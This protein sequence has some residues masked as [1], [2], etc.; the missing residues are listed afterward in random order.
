MLRARWPLVPIL[1]LLAAGIMLGYCV[2][3]R[4]S[5]D[6]PVQPGPP[7][8]GRPQGHVYTIVTEEPEH[9][10]PF[11]VAGSVAR[12]KVLAFTHDTLLETD[13]V[14]GDLRGALAVSWEMDAD[15]LA[16]TCELRQGVQFSDGSPLDPEDILFTWQ[17]AR[18]EDGLLGS[19]GDGM[20][21]VRDAHL[22]PGT[23]PRLR[24]ELKERHFAAL[25]AVAESW[26]VVQRSF[27]VARVA[28]LA[29]QQGLELPRPG[30]PA[31]SRLLAQVRDSGPGSGPYALGKDADGR[32]DWRRGR[33]LLLRRN[34]HC[35]RRQ[36]VPGTWNL[37][38][39]RLLFLTDPAAVFAELLKGNLDW[40]MAADLEQ[41]LQ[42]PEVAQR[43]REVTY[44]YLNLGTFLVLWNTRRPH[45]HDPRVRRA[46]GM[47]FDRAAMVRDL[48]GG[49]GVPAAAY[50]K[51]GTASY[52]T[53]LA[54]LP[55]DP[56]VARRLLREAGIGPE[57]PL[58]IR[59]LFPAGAEL[60]RRTVELAAG[61]ASQAGVDLQGQPL[62]WSTLSAVE[63]K[64]DWDGILWLESHRTWVDPYPLFHSRGG[65]NRM[66]FADAGCDALLEQIRTE[67]DEARRAELSHRL[68]HR[69]HELQPVAFLAH[70]RVAALFNRFIQ[71][72]EP[73]VL[74]LYPERWWVAPEHQRN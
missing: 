28:E 2:A 22:L 68:S 42:R 53:D 40:Y 26:L 18:S 56:E 60:F 25:R 20:R 46:L 66:G 50:F 12:R 27:F 70:P 10:N 45:L 51:P 24:V 34:P 15:G 29:R 8:G 58:R 52:P 21:L 62:V 61:A 71:D 36:A 69:L 41:V 64:G 4:G 23:P 63:E 1:A 47:L 37:A 59:I 55:R 73:G 3:G 67:L 7:Q 16:F 19:M 44:D 49:A 48:L 35:W 74:G 5:R 54:P 38:G 33:D 9:L 65:G 13:P 57:Q 32:S 14:T 39:M 72:A 6:T 43:Y 30:E 17:V 11:T 31:F